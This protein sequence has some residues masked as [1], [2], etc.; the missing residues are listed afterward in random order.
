MQAAVI[1]MCSGMEVADNIASATSL[2]KKAAAAGA[3]LIAT[4]EMTNL[5]VQGKAA[6]SARTVDQSNDPTLKAI[7]KLARDLGVH[8]LV[9]SVAIRK[10]DRFRNRS[11][12][13]DSS[14]KL[15]AHYDKM[16]MFD[17]DVGDGDRWMESNTYEA[18]K[19]PVV[20]DVADLKLGLSICYDLRFAELFR[21]Y[22]RAGCD[23]ISVPAAFTV[24]TGRAHWEVLLRAR[25]IEA[26]AYI[27][28]PAQ[29]GL[30]EDGRQTYGHSMIVAPWGEIVA[31]I[32]GN[33]PSF[34]TAEIDIE[35]VRQARSRVPAWSLKPQL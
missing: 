21:H 34:V 30:H 1:Q 17:A 27:L 32:D 31:E 20:A 33:A 18:G 5:I 3:K 10:G 25:A 12:L 8:I 13:I 26:G 9:G 2:I 14:G 6:L 4:P 28:A 19:R 29:G 15:T 35:M 23:V 7:S 16:H 24:P 11:V 22:A